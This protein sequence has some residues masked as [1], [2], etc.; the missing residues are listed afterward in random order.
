M[1]GSESDVWGL[2]D[3]GVSAIECGWWVVLLGEDAVVLKGLESMKSMKLI[4]ALVL[5]GKAR[6]T[7]IE[8]PHSPGPG[9]PKSPLY[10]AIPAKKSCLSLP[11]VQHCRASRDIMM[12]LHVPRSTAYILRIIKSSRVLL[13]SHSRP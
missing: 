8:L 10:E 13:N 2:C 12:Y 6:T 5:E 9:L 1:S 3:G 4:V 11:S 7:S